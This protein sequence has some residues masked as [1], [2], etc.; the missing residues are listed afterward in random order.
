M[1]PVIDTGTN[2]G[3]NPYRCAGH[4]QPATFRKNPFNR[5]TRSSDQTTARGPN[6]RTKK[7][8]VTAIRR[9]LDWGDKPVAAA[10]HSFDEFRLVRRIAKGLAQLV[11]RG[12]QA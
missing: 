10:R 4:E 2:G 8:R 5:Q 11:D 9:Y 3:R 1:A 7:V 12:I 6:R